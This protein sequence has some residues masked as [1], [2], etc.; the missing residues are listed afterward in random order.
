MMP[1]NSDPRMMSLGGLLRPRMAQPGLGGLHMGG[2]RILP[3]PVPMPTPGIDNGPGRPTADP[4][5]SGPVALPPPA[6]G[7]VVAPP[8]GPGVQPLPNPDGGN[9]G[10]PPPV[11]PPMP[12]P[13]VAPLGLRSPEMGGGGT[14]SLLDL[15]RARQNQGLW[16]PGPM[17]RQAY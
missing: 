12:A 3:Q 5:I 11:A 2:P 8:V 17:G 4:R 6:Q 9:F 16:S 10:Q 7:P 14:M 15:L 1:F 13:P